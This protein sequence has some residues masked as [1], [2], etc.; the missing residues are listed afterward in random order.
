MVPCLTFA[1]MKPCF[2]ALQIVGPAQVARRS[3]VDMNGHINNVTYLCWGLETVPPEVYNSC[4]LY[5]VRGCCLVGKDSRPAGE[6]GVQHE[7]MVNEPQLT[8]TVVNALYAAAALVQHVTLSASSF[9]TSAHPYMPVSRSRMGDA[10]RW[11][12]CSRWQA[13]TQR[14]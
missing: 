11:S 10:M 4:H 14:Q 9:D 8:V 6:A 2:P 5:Q 12:A 1:G 3:D 13:C 7:F